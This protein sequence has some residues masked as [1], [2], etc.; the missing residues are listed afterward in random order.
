MPQ[1]RF[2]VL[3]P[4]GRVRKGSLTSASLEE[5]R[6]QIEQTGLSVVELVPLEDGPAPRLPGRSLSPGGHWTDK[7]IGYPMAACLASLGLAWGMFNWRAQAHHPPRPAPARD[8]TKMAEECQFKGEFQGRVEGGTVPAQATLLLQFPEIPY[9]VSQPWPPGQGFQ[10]QVAFQAAR[11]PGY[12][13]VRLYQGRS[14]LAETR[15]EPLPLGK[16]EFKLELIKDS[17]MKN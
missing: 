13:L 9:Q 1:F 10:C 8:A 6:R 3:T 11:M 15:I 14:L 17:F 5:A 16:S 2:R 4:D 12:C 7:L